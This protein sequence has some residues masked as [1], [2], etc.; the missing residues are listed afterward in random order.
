[1]NQVRM[2]TPTG[3]TLVTNFIYLRRIL[4][5]FVLLHVPE[6]DEDRGLVL[7]LDEGKNEAASAIEKT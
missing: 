4:N 1:M 7:G 5:F 6:V 2:K 3:H